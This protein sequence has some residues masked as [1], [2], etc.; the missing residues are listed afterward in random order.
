[1]VA[2]SDLPDWEKKLVI[3][4][5]RI[6]AGLGSRFIAVEQ[7]DSREAFLDMES[8]VKTVQSAGLGKQLSNALSGRPPFRHFND[9]LAVH[10]EDK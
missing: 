8:F 10:P 6:E 4:V 5:D 1:M 3:D 2:Q 9:F 7:D